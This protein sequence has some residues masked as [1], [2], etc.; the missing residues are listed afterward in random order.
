ML[1]TAKQV[2]GSRCTL[3]FCL[4]FSMLSFPLSRLQ[5]C[6]QLSKSGRSV[7]L[8]LASVLYHPVG[9]ISNIS[10]NISNENHGSKAPIP[11]IQSLAFVC[12][13]YYVELTY[14]EESHDL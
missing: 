10:S 2:P 5:C 4:S 14:F 11:R 1:L 12:K 3:M 7:F 13:A 9:I 8:H 6:L